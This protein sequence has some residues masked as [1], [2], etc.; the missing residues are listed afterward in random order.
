MSKPTD[1]PKDQN[2][3]KN[4]K[5]QNPEDKHKENQESNPI[6]SSSS[7][8]AETEISIVPETT[9][10]NDPYNPKPYTNAPKARISPSGAFASVRTV[11]MIGISITSVGFLG[12]IIWMSFAPLDE[13]V[14]APGRIS[15]DTNRKTVQH[16]E[17]GIVDE[18]LVRDGDTVEKDD[19]L[20]TLDNKQI[21]AKLNALEVRYF[22]TI[23]KSSRLKA[24]I[25]TSSSI[26]Y[27][28]SILERK[29]EPRIADI[30]NT[31]EVVF[32]SRKDAIEGRRSILTNKIEEL[33]ERIQGLEAEQKA[34]SEIKVVV[35]SQL[36]DFEALLEK[37]LIEKPQV[38]DLRRRLSEINGTKGRIDS[39]ISAAKINIGETELEII[40]LTNNMKQDASREFRETNSSVFEIEEQ[41]ASAQDIRDRI[42]IRAPRSGVI[43]GLNVH[44]RGGVIPPGSPILEIV[45]KSDRLVIEAQIKPTDIDNISPGM[46][47]KVQLTAFQ[48]RTTPYL[49]GVL[50]R[51]TADALEDP[52]NNIPFYL[53]RVGVS[54]EELKRLDDGLFLVP[55][56]PAEILIQAGSRTV[57]DYLLAPV[58]TILTRGFKEK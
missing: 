18:I 29:N 40:Q 14:V 34:N 11:V 1:N 4:H 17:G 19:I 55:G 33:K 52:T 9:K 43:V 36:A 51:V 31:Q 16:L 26:K 22:S 2:Y 57:L 49:E 20:I 45:P 38:L 37:G 25:A 50:E 41:L 12:L 23:A 8:S 48:S 46:S 10:N 53:A 28:N 5:S 6:D 56:M 58:T 30:I 47:V 24:E 35:E 21:R 7:S 13:G 27:P 42:E 32:K 15:V 54:E 44:T 3:D 39:S